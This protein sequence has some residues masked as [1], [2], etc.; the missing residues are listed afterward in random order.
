MEDKLRR[1]IDGLF[2]EVPQ[3]KNVV[4]LK[5]EMLQNLREKYE[6]LLHEGKSEEAAFNIAVAGIG[7]INELVGNMSQVSKTVVTE[8]DKQKSAMLTSIAVMLYI[9][10]II[11][12]MLFLGS[13]SNFFNGLI[14]FIVMITLATGTL[15]YN[16]MTKPKYFAVEDT[17]VEDFKEWKVKKE[18]R[19]TTRLSVSVALWSIII[20]LYCIIS[21][22]TFDWHI[23]WVIFIIG[24]AIE[25]LINIF[26]TL[27][28]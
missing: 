24:I 17:M 27:R 1:Y 4:E 9:L 5:E 8:K 22:S 18:N 15:V 2:K 11:P 19:R 26:L 20:S 7:D 21:F 3:T 23:T 28:K 14:G 6:D 12:I 13:S 16:G 25:A 10:S